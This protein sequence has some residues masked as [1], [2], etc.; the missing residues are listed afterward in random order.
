MARTAGET[1]EYAGSD[2]PDGD[3]RPKCVCGWTGEP[4]DT[5]AL[6][7]FAWT[8]HLYASPE[9]RRP[10]G[11]GRARPPAAEVAEAHEV[12]AIDLDPGGFVLR[13]GCGWASPSMATRENV[14][15]RWAKHRTAG[16][17]APDRTTVHREQ[18]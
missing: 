16:E 10:T 9:A 2:E 17:P 4:A 18:R 8:E 3:R 7:V 6:A 15:D 1:H 13:C 12:A 5:E 11:R 14:L